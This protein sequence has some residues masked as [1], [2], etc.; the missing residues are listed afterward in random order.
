MCAK[1]IS[2]KSPSFLLDEIGRKSPLI[3]PSGV[4]PCTYLICMYI[5]AYNIIYITPSMTY[6]YPVL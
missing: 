3:P 1:G 6:P 4:R 5:L 2:Q